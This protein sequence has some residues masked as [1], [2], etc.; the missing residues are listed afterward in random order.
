MRTSD[1]PIHSHDDEGAADRDQSG[2]GRSQAALPAPLPPPPHSPLPP[3]PP[4]VWWV[5][6]GVGSWPGEVLGI[7]IL[8]MAHPLACITPYHLDCVGPS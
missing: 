7:A 4:G 1:R 3:L 2:R 6:L 5:F 8:Q